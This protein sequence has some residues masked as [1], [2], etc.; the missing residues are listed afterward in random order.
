M[1][2]NLDLGFVIIG[3]GMSGI[4]AAIKLREAGF[5][6]VTILEKADRIGGTWR[7]NRYPGLTCDVP[8]HAYTYSFARNPEWSSYYAPGGE[9]QAYFVKVARDYGIYGVTRFNQDV[10][11]C[12][13]EDGAWQLRTKAGEAYSADVVIA[14]SGVLHQPRYPDIEGLGSFGGQMCH[15]A[16]WD[17]AIVLDDRRIGVIGTGSTG[18]QI[19]S[20]VA[21]RASRVSH[22]QRSPQWIMPIQQMM[23]TEEQREAFRRDPAVIDSIRF[24]QEYES[25]VR[26]F[27]TGVSN[28]ETPEMAA[29]ETMCL[30]NLEQNVH[31]PVLREKLRPN[32]RAACKRLVF[33]W[34]YYEVI[35]KYGVDVVTDSIE[36]IEHG[37]VL[38]KDGT[39]HEL[40]VIVLATG[41]KA[42][43]FIRPAVVKGRGRPA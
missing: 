43:R 8:A 7:E 15:S 37:G 3:A 16:R 31:D 28:R 35:Q 26:R 27:T 12:S 13:W 32:Y 34:E 4:L 39:Y 29:I 24:D 40:D 23:Y 6:N 36:R 42:D 1:Q 41:F 2:R 9:I 17:D 21:R 30:E 5:R 10:S 11:S 33:S 19:V 18:V 25:K 14:A 38:T 22:F 20:A